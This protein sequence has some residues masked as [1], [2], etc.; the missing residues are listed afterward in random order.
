MSSKKNGSYRP[1]KKTSH[2]PKMCKN[3]FCIKNE[4]YR[5]TMEVIAQ[6]KRK[7][8][9]KKKA[10]HRPKMCKNMLCIKIECYRRKNGSHRSKQMEVIE[11]KNKL[12]IDQKCTKIC[13]A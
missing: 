10:C 8:S 12:V 7:L 11:Q 6:K 5:K 2:R 1:K 9:N 4:C 13:S 3:M